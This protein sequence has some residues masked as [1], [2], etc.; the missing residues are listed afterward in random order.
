MEGHIVSSLLQKSREI[1]HSQFPTSKKLYATH[2]IL[3]TIAF[4]ALALLVSGGH[5]ELVFVKGF[6]K[7]KIIG[8]TLDDAAGEA[9]DKVA[10]MLGLG[11]PGGPAIAREAA[12]MKNGGLKLKTKLPRP[13]LNSDNYDFSF[14]G[15]KTAVLYLI[16][17]IKDAK[18]IK[19]LR[20]AIAKEFQDA[21]V[22]VLVA[23]TIRAAKEYNVKTILLGGGVAA[24]VNLQENL[25]AVIKKDLPNSKFY[26][27]DSHVTGDNALM[28]ALTAYLSGKKK[29]QNK[30]GVEA[31]LRLS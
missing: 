29:P 4:P 31:N 28:I 8:E 9:F 15:L 23:K 14:S 11:Y 7:Y 16:R 24:N 6:G 13:M 2:H 17:E 3:H 18:K 22:D 27:P 30:V 19:K 5:T 10:R 25:E 1:S 21:A 26:I 12:K 20:P